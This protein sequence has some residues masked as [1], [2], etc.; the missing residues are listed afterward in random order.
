MNKSIY[1]ILA[2]V[3]ILVMNSCSEDEF[4]SRN[5]DM[6]HGTG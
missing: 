1:I 3:G 6:E 4:L 5:L 2:L